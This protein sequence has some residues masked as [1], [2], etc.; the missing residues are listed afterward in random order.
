MVALPS[1]IPDLKP[2][3][4]AVNPGE[5]S[6]SG[7]KDDSRQVRQGDLFIAVSGENYS[8]TQM[9]K[10]IQDSGAAAVVVDAEENIDSAQFGK[11]PLFAL[12]ELSK[13]RGFIAS[14]F[15]GAP[16]ESLYVVGV[17]G[18]NG[19]TSCTQYIAAALDEACGV[20]GTMGWGFPPRLREPGLTTPPAIR[21]QELFAKLAEQE[22]TA[23]CVEASSHGLVQERLAATEI[24]AAVFTNLTRDHLDYHGSLEAYK[25]AKKQLFVDFP[26][27]VAVL[28]IDDEFAAEISEALDAKTE[29]LSYSLRNP[30]ADIFC[31][32]LE[33]GLSGVK[34]VVESPFGQIALNT[35]LI[36]D[37]NVSNLLA[38][39]GVLGARGYSPTAIGRRVGQLKNVKGRMDCVELPNDA[40]AIIDYAHTPDALENVLRALRAHCSGN[41]F[42]VMGCGGDRDNGKRPQMGDIASRLAD[43]VVV[44]DDNPRTEPAAQII[45]QILAG[46]KDRSHTTAISDRREAINF[47][48]QQCQPD[49]I[50]LIAG[51]GHENYQ[52]INGVR[53]T[54]SDHAEVERYASNSARQI[55]LGLGVTGQSFVRYCAD[56]NLEFQVLDDHPVE[57][58]LST[59]QSEIGEFQVSQSIDLQDND[60]L[61]LSPGV[62]MSHPVVQTAKQK[63]L[64]ISNDIQLFADAVDEPL[65][66]ITGSNGKSTVTSF[67][68]QLLSHAGLDAKLGGNIG[69]PV[70][71][72]LKQEAAETYVLEVSSYQLEVATDCRPSVAMLLNLA[73]DHL[74][75]YDCLDDYYRAKTNV[76]NGAKLAIYNREIEF[77]L[78]LSEQTRVITFGLDEPGEGHYGI[79]TVN[80]EKCLSFGDAVITSVSS[81]PFQSNH[82]LLNLLAAFA[83]CEGLGASR[84]QIVEGLQGLVPLEHRFEVLSDVTKHL[85]I[86]DSKSTNPASTLAALRSLEQESRDIYLLL[87]GLGKGADFSVLNETIRQRVK[88][89]LVFGADRQQIQ[90]Q[91]KAK[92]EG[93]ESLEECLEVLNL[94]QLESSVLL[95]SPGCAS[96]DQYRNYIERG[97]LF[98]NQVRE[99]LL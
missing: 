70:L 4:T 49:D 9:L 36:G 40:L 69:I 82:E 35:R 97:Q 85:V 68:G 28:N 25:A 88:A 75:R 14:R 12:E 66:L 34:G 63:G 3:H 54:F 37:F 79:R 71:E 45:D 90:Q 19:K 55:V 20:V 15:F 31:S 44:T 57:S 96:Q 78:G 80:G 1:I 29:V 13:Q 6:I 50:V 91:I 99:V 18:T 94:D 2:L 22:A 86:N 76:F 67:V 38:V 48:L 51:K 27:K 7:L 16:T 56:N 23:V 26:I 89:C 60:R 30:D 81:L 42:C 65:C 47:A 84:E 64:E 74:D 62:P 95:F 87:G 8:A 73:P 58:V 10:D 11:V 53:H 33:F 77:D 43:V 72:L 83:A 39:I 41:L 59:L 61:L 32:E 46:I 21:L 52:E 17:T 98:K 24:D 93:Y 5:I 92:T